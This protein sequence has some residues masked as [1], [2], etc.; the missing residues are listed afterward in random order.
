MK[1]NEPLGLPQGSVRAI[2]TII[3]ILAVIGMSFVGST[4]E[5]LISL[6]SA[7]FGYYFG[8]R[9][10]ETTQIPRTE[11]EVIEPML[12]GSEEEPQVVVSGDQL[13]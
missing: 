9:A 8:T 7:A 12:G 11:T 10:S 13:Q 4:S 1:F 5:F 3:L 6:T 2:I